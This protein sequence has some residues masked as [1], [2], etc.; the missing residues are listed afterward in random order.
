[1]P[2]SQMRRCEKYLRSYDG[3][4]GGT[5]NVVWKKGICLSPIGWTMAEAL[6]RQELSPVNDLIAYDT[7][8]HSLHL[9]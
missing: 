3:G 2:V 6:H 8:D 1:M 5:V 9:V 4:E 7:Q